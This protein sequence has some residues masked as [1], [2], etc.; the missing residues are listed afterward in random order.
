MTVGRV[1]DLA[2]DAGKPDDNGTTLFWVHVIPETWE[3][4]LFGSYAAG[5][6][7]NL[8]FDLLGK[9]ILRAQDLGSAR[10]R[11]GS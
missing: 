2:P 4:T 5:H 9:Y 7:V 3:R 8:E 6:E 11:N 10:E 1:H